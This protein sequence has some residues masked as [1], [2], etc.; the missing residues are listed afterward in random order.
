MTDY[1]LE[2]DH[3]IEELK[4]E[5]AQ[6]EENMRWERSILDNKKMRIELAEE[7]L[8]EMESNP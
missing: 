1:E 5:Y 3:Y 8:K 4:A 6:I 7:R 2:L